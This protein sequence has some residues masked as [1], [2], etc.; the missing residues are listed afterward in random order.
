VS[1][2]PS[3]SGLP[4]R[5]TVVLL[6][7]ILSL[8]L[9]AAAF[10]HPVILIDYTM[11]AQFDSSGLQGFHE[12]WR[13]DDVHSTEILKMF[14][15]NGNGQIDPA[16][17][18]ALKRGYFDDLKDYSYFASIL[19]NGKEVPT[20]EVSDFSATYE[21]HRMIYR[22]FVPLKVPATARDQEV[23]V[24]VWDPTYFT[25]LSP[26]GEGAFTID[27]PDGMAAT[28][29]IANDRRHFYNLGPGVALVKKPPFYLKMV[30]V[31][32][33]IAS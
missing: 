11:K 29:S 14:D 19:V 10:A 28:L 27:K 2:S 4:Q 31:R 23:D 18:P 30:V 25:D 3:G 17:L 9:P 32:F 24:T 20:R 13:F 6:A 16:E 7:F 15:K 5:G 1:Q 21:D 8:G 33:Q 12:T 22:F 26:D